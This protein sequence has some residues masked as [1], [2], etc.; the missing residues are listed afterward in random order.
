MK[1]EN[2]YEAP[3]FEIVGMEVE[4]HVFSLSGET[5]IDDMSMEEW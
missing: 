4:G 3:S 1:K 5:G 2:F